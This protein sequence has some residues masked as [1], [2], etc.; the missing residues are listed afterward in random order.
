M[1]SN[2]YEPANF[3]RLC[4]NLVTECK[5]QLDRYVDV[6]AQVTEDANGR[7]GHDDAHHQPPFYH[8]LQDAADRLRSLSQTNGHR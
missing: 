5:R 1:S 8:H 2:F 3:W 7:H 6:D 4:W